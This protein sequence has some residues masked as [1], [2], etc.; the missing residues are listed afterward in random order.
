MT[1][2]VDPLREQ[3]DAFKSLD[4]DSPI[5]MLN[6]IRLHQNAQYAD[7][8]KASG[9]EA[10]LAYGRETEPVFQAV[11]GSIFWRGDPQLVL[12]GPSEEHWDIAFIAQYPSAHAFM[13][14]VTNP[15]YKVAVLH[16]QAAVDDSRLI[17][18][19]ELPAGEN[20]S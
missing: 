20:F 5:L 1:S 12:I 4:R 15:D 18:R 14:M 9:R 3:F 8:R 19:G 17:R 16:R 10:Y 7:G 6:L 2:H 11:G 13:Q